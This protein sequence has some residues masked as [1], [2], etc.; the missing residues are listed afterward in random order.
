[1]CGRFHNTQ[2]PEAIGHVFGCRAG[3]NS[4]PNFNAAPTQ[5]LPVVV[6]GADGRELRLMTWGLVPAWSKD[7]KPG[8]TTINARAETV[9]SK[10]TYRDAFRRR[11]CLVPA[12]GFY[13]WQKLPDGGKQPYS[14]GL[15][16]GGL[17]GMAGIWER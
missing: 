3:V 5:R 15:A 13:E 7:G 6:Q 12:D 11:R 14:I 10:P 8:Y 9:D 4:P 16:D 1:M 2:P 17:F